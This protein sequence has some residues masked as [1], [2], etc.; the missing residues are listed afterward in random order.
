MTDHDNL[1]RNFIDT[2][3][4]LKPEANQE[5]IT[6]GDLLDRLDERAFGLMIL[7][8][9]IPCLVPGLPGAQL[10]AI[11]IILLA[12]QMALG[13]TE[14]WLPQ[15]VLAASVKASWITAI[16]DFADKRLRWT[17]RLSRP[18]LTFAVSG[19]GERLVAVAM[20]LAAIT[21]ALPI[22]NTIPSLAITLASVGL[23]QRDG[24]FAGAGA[25]LAVGWLSALV[26]LIVGLVTGASFAVG[27]VREHFPW[28]AGLF[29]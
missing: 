20:M 3:I 18:R 11:P 2:L 24:L 6:L 17:T 28:L 1:S 14:P 10:I 19:F 9:T 16:A 7:L 12:G 26:I 22:T 13:R 4:S 8:L 15:K 29:S 27:F 5:S 25:I 21:I 23:I